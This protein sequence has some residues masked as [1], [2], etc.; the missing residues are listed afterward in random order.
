MAE[1]LTK[2]I[3]EFGEKHKE[4]I[5]VFYLDAGVCSFASKEDIKNN[6]IHPDC[7]Y[8]NFFEFEEEEDGFDMEAYEEHYDMDE[9]EK[10]NSEY[11]VTMKELIKKLEM[12]DVFSKNLNLSENFRIELP[13]HNY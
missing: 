4:E 3:K 2:A 1:K 11:K 12:E 7:T 13:K 10:E 8:A 5:V 9:E 6:R